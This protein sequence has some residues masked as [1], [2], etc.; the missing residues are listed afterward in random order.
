M[1]L[2]FKRRIV[3]PDRSFF[4]LGPRGTGKSTW[5][6]TNLPT[7]RRFDLLS[8]ELYQRLLTDPAL[9][10]LELR[11][12]ETGSWVII[13]EIQRLP[14]LLNEAHRFIEERGLRFAL[15]GSSARK[16]KRAGVNLLAGRAVR[17][18]MHPF[19]PEELADAFD[20]NSALETGLLPIVWSA[21]NRRD[22]LD[23]YVQHYLKE[24]IQAEA[25]VR[26]LA[27]FARFLPVAAIV[28]G[29]VINTSNIAR[30]CGVSR[31]TVAGYLEIL[32][33]T[34]LAFTVPAYESKLRVRERR[35]PK[36][37]W[38]DPG[39]VRAVK[40]ARG[41]VVPEER[42]ALFEGLVMQLLRAYRD[43][44]GL[45]DDIFYWAAGNQSDIEVDAILKRGEEIVAVE[46]KSGKNF[47]PAWVK[48][49]RAL[50]RL[51]G[52]RRRLIVYPEG[53]DLR[54][55]DGIEVMSLLSFSRAVAAGAIW[56]N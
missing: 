48:G 52:L 43:Y 16:L 46:I 34:L 44:I 23:T 28:H 22:V 42:G 19:L 11:T 38:C 10:A 14:N 25:L 50:A 2:S 35:L 13:D 31:T 24:E 26:N 18:S 40:K 47:Q 1:Q 15:C 45:C 30:E 33:E 21:S 49:L 9:L 56:P 55:E 12:M 51:P 27:G 54:T 39:L 29:R 6:T 7:A 17:R 3:L 37:Y 8:E 5:L 41:P 53:P 32:E 4:L 36:M 20:L